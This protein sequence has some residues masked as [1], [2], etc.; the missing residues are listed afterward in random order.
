MLPTPCDRFRPRLLRDHA[1]STRL[2]APFWRTFD[3]RRQGFSRDQAF[4]FDFVFHSVK[5][6]VQ[7]RELFRCALHGLRGP[8]VFQLL[9]DICHAL[10]ADGEARSLQRVRF[11]TEP[12]CLTVSD[13]R[14]QRGTVLTSAMLKRPNQLTDTYPPPI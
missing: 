9:A 12:P 13:G 8:E 5:L 1:F 6:A 14:T 4:L 7:P 10:R 3:L 2:P 11:S